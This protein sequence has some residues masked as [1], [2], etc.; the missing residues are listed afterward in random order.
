[1]YGTVIK[2]LTASDVENLDFFEGKVRFKISM[3]CILTG[4]SK[5]IDSL[6]DYS[7]QLVNPQLLAPFTSITES[8]SV[9]ESAT[10]SDSPSITAFTYAWN[11]SVEQLSLEPWS[12]DTFVRERLLLWTAGP[13][14]ADHR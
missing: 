2:G 1:V 9:E 12:Y 4:F 8:L 10:N 7:H 13:P 3:T 11:S 5:A 6:W 14:S